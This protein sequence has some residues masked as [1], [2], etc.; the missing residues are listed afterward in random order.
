[1][2]NCEGA[3]LW[4][5]LFSNRVQVSWEAF[6]VTFETF[7]TGKYPT[8][9]L[10]PAVSVRRLLFYSVVQENANVTK[11]AF[12]NFVQLF[13]PIRYVNYLLSYPPNVNIAIE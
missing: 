13:G 1:M 10:P 2:S 6:V 3:N 12:F 8:S 4:D 5:L 9:Y 7:F 11:T